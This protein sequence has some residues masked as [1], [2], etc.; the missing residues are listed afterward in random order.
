M[1][2]ATDQHVVDMVCE[3]ENLCE[4]DVCGK[5]RRAGWSLGTGFGEE[6]WMNWPPW[7]VVAA[8]VCGD[9]VEG[10]VDSTRLSRSARQYGKP[11]QERETEITE[12]EITE[13]EITETERDGTGQR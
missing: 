6:G 2:D 4:V 10:R 13:T 5:H 8:M 1:K 11:L 7:C 3:V 9:S 12:T